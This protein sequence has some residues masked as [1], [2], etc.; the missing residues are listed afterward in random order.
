[1]KGRMLTVVMNLLTERMA[2]RMPA[3]GFQNPQISSA[4]VSHSD[5]PRK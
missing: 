3:F 1:M 2:P 4:A 5:T